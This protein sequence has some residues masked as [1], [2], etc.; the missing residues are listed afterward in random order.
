MTHSATQSR[1][2]IAATFVASLSCSLGVF[3]QVAPAEIDPAAEL[4]NRYAELSEQLEQSPIQPGLYLES[5]ETS[6]SSRGDIYAVAGFGFTTIS[7]TFTHP[8]NWCE[9]LILHLNVKY[10][11]VIY[12]NARPVLSVALGKKTEQPLKDTHRVE[13]TYEITASGPEYTQVM[14]GAKKGP[15]GTRNYH[16]LLESIA[17]DS[18]RSFLHI[19]YAYGYGLVARIAMRIYLSNSEGAKVGF[20]MIESGKGGPPRYVGGMRAAQERNTMRYFL[21]IDAYLGAL[22]SPAADRFEDSLERWFAATERHALQLH[23]VDHDRYIAMKRN[24]Y[25][26]QQQAPP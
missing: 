3:A 26:R 4:R 14:L 10:C 24:E 16:I 20:T 12:R 25:L 2:R 21:A 22:T 8:A 13:F 7:D 19:R 17:L 1:R 11:R 9:A 15:L 6:R 5:A 23:E 18:D